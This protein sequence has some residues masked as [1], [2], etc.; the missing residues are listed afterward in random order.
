MTNSSSLQYCISALA[1]LNI[2][3]NISFD[4]SGVLLFIIRNIL[5]SLLD[6]PS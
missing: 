1:S 4:V 3:K 5:F 2:K 6:W